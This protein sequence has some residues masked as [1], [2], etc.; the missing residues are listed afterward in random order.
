MSVVTDDVRKRLFEA[1]GTLLV[2]RPATGPTPDDVFAEIV[3]H[4][5]GEVSEADVDELIVELDVDYWL[6]DRTRKT[7]QWGAASS[8]AEVVL[9]LAVAPGSEAF[10]ALLGVAIDRL[11]P[12]RS[13]FGGMPAEEAAEHA[14]RMRVLTKYQDVHDESL[15]LTGEAEDAAAGTRTFRFRDPIHDFEVEVRTTP[16]GFAF[17]CAVSRAYR[18]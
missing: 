2:L 14:A 17:A 10:W 11:I 8:F 9:Q 1:D 7:T 16:R 12:S 15:E 13:Q 18:T 5:P 3:L 6:A 4:I